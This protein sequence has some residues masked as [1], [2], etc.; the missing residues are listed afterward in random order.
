M[1]KEDFPFPMRLIQI[2]TEANWNGRQFMLVK[3]N[4][5]I[6]DVDEE[7]PVELTAEELKKN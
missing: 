3:K 7:V 6:P 5:W 1:K 4:I 2:V